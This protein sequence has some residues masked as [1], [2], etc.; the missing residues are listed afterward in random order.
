MSFALPARLPGR[1]ASSDA[2]GRTIARLTRLALVALGGLLVLL[3]VLIAPLPGPMGLPVVVVGMILILRN[4]YKARRAFV[5]A[6]RAHPRLLYPLRRLLRR[7]PEVAP[8]AWQTVLKLERLVVPRR[9]RMA[10]RSRRPFRR[11]GA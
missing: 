1:P 4:S 6:Q 5:R 3:G 8:V 9:F 11:K 10:S 2:F 7:R